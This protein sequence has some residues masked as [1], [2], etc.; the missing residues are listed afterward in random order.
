MCDTW[1]QTEQ[2][3]LAEMELERKADASGRN[4]LVEYEGPENE[5]D[6]VR[7]KMC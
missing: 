7:P 5:E 1:V 3:P 2:C 6:R 4:G